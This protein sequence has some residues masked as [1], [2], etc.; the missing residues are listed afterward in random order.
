MDNNFYIDIE[1][2]YSFSTENVIASHSASGF[3]LVMITIPFK[4]KIEYFIRHVDK[5]DSYFDYFPE[6]IKH[7]NKHILNYHYGMM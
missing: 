4:N 2:F 7:Y 1:D 5:H 3:Y 6:V